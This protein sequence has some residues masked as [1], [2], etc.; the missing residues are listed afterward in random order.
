MR[1]ESGYISDHRHEEDFL[2]VPH[3]KGNTVKVF[4]EVPSKPRSQQSGHACPDLCAADP[5]MAGMPQCALGAN[6]SESLRG[7]KARLCVNR[8]TTKDWSRPRSGR[9]S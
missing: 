8:N 4:G 5:P 7:T 6:V 3:H 9:P 1:R 2:K